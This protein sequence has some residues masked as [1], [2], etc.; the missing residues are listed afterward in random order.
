MIAVW[1]AAIVVLLGTGIPAFGAEPEGV[2]PTTPAGTKRALI[3]CGLPGDK[4][5]RSLYAK[6]LETIRTALVERYHFD[7]SAVHVRFGTE[8]ESG[9]GPAVSGSRGLASREGIEAEVAE[10]RKELKPEDTLWVIVLGH[11]HL[12]GRHA[13]LN[14]PGPDLSDEE[15]GKLFTGL[16]AR[17][18]VFFITTSSS[19]FFLKALSAPGRVVITATEP[20]QE[21][22][23][24]VF[25]LALADVLSEPPAGT[26]YDKD[27]SYSVLDLYLAVTANILKRFADDEALPTEHA[28]L[29]DNGDGRGTE[30]QLR[31]LPPELLDPNSK[32]EEPKK[33]GAKKPE[34]KKPDPTIGPKDDG[35][36]AA[37]IRLEAV[38]ATKS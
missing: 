32:P 15:F 25:P 37:K 20:D 30:L 11:G 22:N 3:L 1:R 36:A 27:G 4:D 5:H 33:K 16:K 34:P 24:T 17:E 6:A 12:D 8:T 23:E 38:P 2:S 18:T 29:D 35:A 31:F 14:L 19:G 13:H 28:R 9:D 26:D 7:S 21:V 10:L